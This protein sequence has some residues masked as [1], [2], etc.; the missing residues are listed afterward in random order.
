M[1]E[2]NGR[3]VPEALVP[4]RVTMCI[5]PTVT[6]NATSDWTGITIVA[7]DAD[8]HWWVLRAIRLLEV[9]SVVGERAV[10]LIR[11]FQPQIVQI[12]SAQADVEM[13]G[14]IQRAISEE[15]IPSVISSYHPLRDE[16]MQTGRRKKS[17]RIEALEPRFRNG[18]I[19]LMRGACEALY[20]QYRSWPDVE[21][22]GDD[23]FDALAMQVGVAKP[24]RFKTFEEA[25]T[26]IYDADDT[27]EAGKREPFATVL[28][29]RYGNPITIHAD[30]EG[31]TEP[32]PM[33][34]AG[35]GTQFLPS[36]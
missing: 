6:A 12:E 21:G 9:P 33:G 22:I 7:D 26:E 5:D 14:R 15:R 4:V 29:D 16:R 28:Y 30:R 34:R 1:R 36:R 31:K 2:F 32:R 25:Q 24:C 11:E 10:A 13:V 27:E 8:D 3:M 19:T 18:K 35:V 20:D 17:A 23:V